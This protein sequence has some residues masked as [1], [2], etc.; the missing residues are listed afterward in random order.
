MILK[1][2]KQDKNDYVIYGGSK[3][4]VMKIKSSNFA[5]NLFIYE[6]IPYRHIF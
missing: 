5:N 2:C 4:E 3:E 6:Y 1:L